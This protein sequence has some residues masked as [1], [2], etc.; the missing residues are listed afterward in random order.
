[1]YGRYKLSATGEEVAE[2]FGLVAVVPIRARYNIA[3]TQ[4]ALVTRMEDGDRPVGRVM[5]WG[6]VPS[7]AKDPTIGSRMINARAETVA[8]KPAFRV[9]F[10]REDGRD[11]C[12]HVTVWRKSRCPPSSPREP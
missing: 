12:G 11:S 8:D 1:M 2:A 4:P 9:A 3:P 7:W 6:L 10:P 5:Q